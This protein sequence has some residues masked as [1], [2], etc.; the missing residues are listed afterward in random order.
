V[1]KLDTDLETA[2]VLS[3]R[4]SGRFGGTTAVRLALNMNGAALKR[5]CLYDGTVNPQPA[6]HRS[7]L[8]E[9]IF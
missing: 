5:A 4:S 7:D 2:P 6:C 9:K 8:L 1:R 3:Q